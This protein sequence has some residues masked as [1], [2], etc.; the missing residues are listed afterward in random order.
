MDFGSIAGAI[1]NGIGDYIQE[2]DDQKK[3]AFLQKLEQE[4]EDNAKADRD[5]QFAWQ[6]QQAV[7]T[8][9]YVE[10][11]AAPRIVDY[12]ATGKELRSRS[13]S[14]AEIK[15][16]DL[17]DRAEQVKVDEIVANT[18]NAAAQS[19][20]LGIVDRLAQ[21]RNPAEIDSLRANAEYAR[22]LG[23]QSGVTKAPPNPAGF[24]NKE[25]LAYDAVIQVLANTPPAQRAAKYAQLMQQLQPLGMTSVIKRLQGIQY[26]KVDSPDEQ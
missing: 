25:Q 3:T 26:N 12:D 24:T 7:R 9:V 8:N 18:A 20:H 17:A 21:E 11:G 6:S 15:D 5:R 23:R 13:A 1:G 22:G 10:D 2:R 14:P 4:K 16:H 19:T